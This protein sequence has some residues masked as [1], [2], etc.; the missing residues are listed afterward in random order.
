VCTA[1]DCPLS[2]NATCASYQNVSMPAVANSS[3]IPSNTASGTATPLMSATSAGAASGTATKPAT[4]STAA[5]A[6]V[7]MSFAAVA[8]GLA[9]MFL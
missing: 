5:G 7:G 8:G 3:L 6:T 2:P 4:V 9:A 1:P